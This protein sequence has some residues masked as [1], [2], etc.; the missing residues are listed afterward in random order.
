MTS[1]KF[2]VR[3][4]WFKG[5][6]QHPVLWNFIQLAL[7]HLSSLS[8]TLHSL[9]SL[10][11]ST[12]T[13]NLVSSNLLSPLTPCWTNTLQL[14]TSD[15]LFSEKKLTGLHYKNSILVVSVSRCFTWSGLNCYFKVLYFTWRLLWTTGSLGYFTVNSKIRLNW[16]IWKRMK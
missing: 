13:P 1:S 2:S 15:F 16:T 3:E 7:A 10:P 9:P 5:R 14:W 4:M 11:W 6:T 8:R 12:L